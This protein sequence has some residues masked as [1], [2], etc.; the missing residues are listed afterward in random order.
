[1]FGYAVETDR[2]FYL[3]NHIDVQE[4]ANGWLEVR[5]TDAWVWDVFRRARFVSSVR[6]LTRHEVNIEELRR[7]EEPTIPT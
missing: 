4:H 3:A 7:D 6:V 2:R 5:L 1:M